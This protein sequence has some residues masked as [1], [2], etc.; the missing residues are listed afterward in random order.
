MDNKK[1]AII[2]IETSGLYCGEED[3]VLSRI[4]RIDAIK[5][6]NGEIGENFSS[7][8]ACGK[9]INKHVRELTGISNKILKG[10][11]KINT[12]LKQLKKFTKGYV[13]YARNSEF[14]NK[15]LSYYGKK[16]G[17]QIDL[18]KES[19]YNRISK[20]LDHDNKV[21][22]YLKNSNDTELIALAK[23]LVAYQGD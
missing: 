18:A 1:L 14:V 13:V 19:Y 15:F 8:V 11:P 9:Y 23:L 7:L 16:C 6:E 3:K 5:I 20:F 21:N 17:V 10:A 22:E 2:D 4:L 12:V